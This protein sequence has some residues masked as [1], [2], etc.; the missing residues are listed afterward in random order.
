[1]ESSI[2]LVQLPRDCVLGLYPKGA[3]QTSACLESGCTRPSYECVF[4][5]RPIKPTKRKPP[6]KEAFAPQWQEGPRHH[7]WKDFQCQHCGT[8]DEAQFYATMKGSC[9]RCVQLHRAKTRR[10]KMGK[11]IAVTCRQCGEEFC[12][13]PGSHFILCRVCRKD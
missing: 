7:Q 12:K 8:T 1:M 10:E 5:T 11:S 13:M 2:E 6:V 9:K 3:Y 4:K